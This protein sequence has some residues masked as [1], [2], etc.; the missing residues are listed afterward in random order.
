VKSSKQ[1]KLHCTLYVGWSESN[2]SHL[3]PWQTSRYRST[4][5]VFDRTNSQQQNNVF[6]HSHHPYLHCVNELSEMPFVS[7]CDSCARLSGTW[8]VFHVAVDSVETHHPPPHCAHIHCLVSIALI[9]VNGCHFFCMEE[10][11]YTPLLHT[12]FHD[13]CHNVRIPLCCHL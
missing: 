5:T 13:R 9:Y 3:S 2:V 8:L 6:Q 10:F 4:I 12:H 1:Q 7:W 11:N